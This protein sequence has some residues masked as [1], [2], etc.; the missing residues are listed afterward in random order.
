MARG[1]KPLPTA[2]KRLRGNPGKRKLKPDAAAPLPGTTEPQ[3]N[4]I[5]SLPVP[6]APA[7]LSDLAQEEWRRIARELVRL[8]LL[9]QL[10]ATAFEIRCE[11]YATLRRARN[12]LVREGETYEHNGVVRQRPEVKIAQDCIRQ[13]RHYDSEFGLT[14]AARARV[15]HVTGPAP[16]QPELP[17]LPPKPQPPAAAEAP[18]SPP[19]PA[20]K[21]TDDDYWGS[22]H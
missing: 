16:N 3:P 18:Q 11:L 1:R 15:A 17:G 13:M 9:R 21:F 10:D 4:D 14:P 12:T 5:A 8:G 22:V 19:A 6:P 7:H 20:Q 2:V